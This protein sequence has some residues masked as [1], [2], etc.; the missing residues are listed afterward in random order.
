MRETHAQKQRR[1]YAVNQARRERARLGNLAAKQRL[2]RK[3]KE[4]K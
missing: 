1:A 4:A 3:A 2:Q